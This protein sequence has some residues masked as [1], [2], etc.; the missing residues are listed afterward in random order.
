MRQHDYLSDVTINKIKSSTT[1]QIN[2]IN[3]RVPQAVYP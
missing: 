2:Q 1:M 3:T